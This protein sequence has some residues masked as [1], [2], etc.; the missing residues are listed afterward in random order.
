MC[1]VLDDVKQA[2]ASLPEE[3]IGVRLQVAEA[4]QINLESCPRRVEKFFKKNPTARLSDY[5]C[6]IAKTLQQDGEYINRLE[7]DDN[8]AWK[9]LFERQRK[10]A[11][12]K[13]RADGWSRDAAS[14]RADDIAQRACEK[15]RRKRYPRDVPFPWWSKKVGRNEY[16]QEYTRGNDVLDKPNQLEPFESSY[17]EESVN[18]TASVGV[19][20]HQLEKQIDTIGDIIRDAINYIA[21]EKQ[22]RLLEL[23]LLDY[24]TE[25]ISQI[26]KQSVRSIYSL[27]HRA[28]KSLKAILYEWAEQG[29]LAEV[30]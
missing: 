12:G 13:L 30:Y 26:M 23:D 18:L 24:T 11:Y 1:F 8:E 6:L 19:E 20:P 22:R 25:E 4:L 29:R 21:V 16:L 27:R 15:M 10:V 28:I 3:Y 9:E 5:A 7:R 2:I 14:Q 17:D